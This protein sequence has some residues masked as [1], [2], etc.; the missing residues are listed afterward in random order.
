VHSHA[1]YDRG[2]S[3]RFVRVWP[4]HR[5]GVPRVWL[6]IEDADFERQDSVSGVLC[7]SGMWRVAPWILFET[8]GILWMAHA[9]I[10]WRFPVPSPFVCFSCVVL[11]LVVVST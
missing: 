3:L 6:N 8:L 7:V 9:F 11:V 10:A 2:V 1:Q 5:G 4:V